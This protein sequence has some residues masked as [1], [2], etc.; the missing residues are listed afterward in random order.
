MMRRK[1]KPPNRHRADVRGQP[2]D[3]V[4]QIHCRMRHLSIGMIFIAAGMAV[5]FYWNT[6]GAHIASNTLHA[7]GVA[8][9]IRTIG[10]LFRY[11]V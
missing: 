5:E 1:S 7:F 4:R 2:K 3:K 11:D 8:P 6:P 10:D 9:F